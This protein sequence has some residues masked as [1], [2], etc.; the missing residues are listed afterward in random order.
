MVVVAAWHPSG[1][2]FTIRVGCFNCRSRRIYTKNGV[3][4][5]HIYIGLMGNR[6][7]PGGVKRKEKKR[8]R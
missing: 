8:K 3:F 4:S 2:I 5:G 6:R 7:R 1:E